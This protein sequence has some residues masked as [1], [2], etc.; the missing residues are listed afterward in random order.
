MTVIGRALM[1]T[2]RLMLLDEASLGLAPLMTKEIFGIIKVIAADEKHSVLMVE[3]NVMAAL[4]IANRGFVMENGK[5]VLDGTADALLKNEDVR[6]F[7]LG[8]SQLGEKTS[9]RKVKHYKRRKR[10]L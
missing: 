6:E 9:Y 3:Q 8:L 7:Y 2:P 5:V 1:A 10:W 4:A